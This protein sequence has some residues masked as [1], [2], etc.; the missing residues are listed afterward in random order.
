MPEL[1]GAFP[2]AYVIFR[3]RTHSVV[4]YAP[5]CRSDSKEVIYILHAGLVAEICLCSAHA[6]AVPNQFTVVTDY[7]AKTHAGHYAG[8]MLQCT[9]TPA[10][11]TQ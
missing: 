1:G 3:R 4:C 7:G 9:R 2:P 8:N 10:R 5:L 11:G 6:L